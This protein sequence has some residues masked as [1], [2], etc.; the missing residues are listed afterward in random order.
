MKHVLTL[1]GKPLD[2]AVV[3]RAAALAEA[4]RAPEWLAPGRACDLALDGPPPGE[5][6]ARLRASLAGAA[7]DIALQPAAG[8]RR[9]LLIADMDST[10]ITVECIDEM[11]AAFGLGAEIARITRRAMRGELDFPS[12]L[13]ERVAMLRG[14]AVADLERVWRERVGLTAGGRVLVRTM[15]AHGAYTALVSGGFDVFTSRVRAAIGFDF[16]LANRL[17]V[18]DGRLTGELVEPVLDADAKRATLARLLSERGLGA[19]DALAV[20][21][22]A[23][24]RA[25][26]Q[27]AGLGV[28]YR[29]KPVLAEVADVRV[30]YGDLST[31]LFIQGYR[32]TD[33]VV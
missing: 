14:F 17:A 26:I 7:I 9:A 3:A 31:L 33:F 15:R 21:D 5:L 4:R 23:N 20:G 8:R 1:I 22:G 16:D 27:A 28:A 24:D 6:E 18:D 30:E 2:A 25:M 12:A 10:F 11:A 19:A 29:A 32:E 13:R